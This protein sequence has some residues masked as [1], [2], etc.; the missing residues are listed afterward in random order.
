MYFS[1]VPS[2]IFSFFNRPLFLNLLFE[3]IA[4][5]NAYF[6]AKFLTPDVRKIWLQNLASIQPITSPV[7]FARSPRTDPPGAHGDRP[8]G[9]VNDFELMVSQAVQRELQKLQAYIPPGAR[10]G[11]YMHGQYGGPPGAHAP[12]GAPAP[13]LGAYGRPQAAAPYLQN[14]ASIQPRTSPVRFKS[15]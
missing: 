11:T 4:N 1:Y 15:I 10:D 5:S 13:D 12:P 14:L 3:P 9:G 2:I 8:L 7:K 6:L